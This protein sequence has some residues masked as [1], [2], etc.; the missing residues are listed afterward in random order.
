MYSFI[1]LKEMFTLSH[2]NDRGGARFLVWLVLPCLARV[3]IP[4]P[5]MGSAVALV[6]SIPPIRNDSADLDGCFSDEHGCLT[7]EC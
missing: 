1:V 6:G 5:P 4:E 2:S 3:N 7:I